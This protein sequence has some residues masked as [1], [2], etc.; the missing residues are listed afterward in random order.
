MVLY[1]IIFIGGMALGAG[2]VL[3]ARPV[4]E[5]TSQVFTPPVSVPPPTAYTGNTRTYSGRYA[6]HGLYVDDSA[7]NGRYGGHTPL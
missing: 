3:L 1:L 6:G 4:S 5:D 7:V 2:A